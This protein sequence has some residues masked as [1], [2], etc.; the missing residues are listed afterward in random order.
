MKIPVLNRSLKS[1]ILNSSNFY[2]D[3]TL[4][5]KSRVLNTSSSNLDK[6]LWGVLSV[7]VEQSRR[8]GN[9]VAQGDG[10]FGTEV[11]KPRIPPN[12]K[13]GAT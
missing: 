1:S 3:K 5:I 10:K 8:K 4:W 2:L 6:T 13:I 7:A 11:D 12:Q 9:M